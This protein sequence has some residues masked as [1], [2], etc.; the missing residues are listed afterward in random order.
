MDDFLI[1]NNSS[2]VQK[3]KGKAFKWEED[4]HFV[5]YLSLKTM[6]IYDFD[7][8]ILFQGEG[9]SISFGK[10]G[11]LI[12]LLYSFYQS[13]NLLKKI[14][15]DLVYM[16]YIKYAPFFGALLSRYK[17]CMEINGDDK[18][19]AR[20]RSN[21]VYYYICLTE[22]LVLKNVDAFIPVSYE[23]EE[24]YKRFDRSSLVIGNGIN[25]SNYHVIELNNKVPE[26][27]F[28]SSPNQ[29]WQGFDKILKMAKYFHNWNFNIIGID[30][31]SKGNVKYFGYMSNKDATEIIQKCD[32][33]I[34]TLSSYVNGL[35]EASPL[36]TRHYLACGLPV[37]YAYK[38][39][40]L[41]DNL[42]FT[43]RLEN[44]IDNINFKIIERFVQRVFGDNCLR[45]RAR[46]E[47][48]DTLNSN[49]KES[50]RLNFFNK[51]INS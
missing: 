12:N 19:E 51:I 26:L 20:L 29:P 16:R 7:E 9:C 33:G 32:V 18:L 28:V 40:D 44:K 46:K 14:E 42:D 30:G 4:G 50:Q 21:L 22:N 41:D 43:L 23:L 47:A 27:V 10:I 25:V 6:A 34:G 1:D 39:T 38:D 48:E 31:D 5:Y 3:I 49:L 11:K 2:I 35:D 45:Y 24:K 17:V 13:S 37:I 15:I 36:K 8:N